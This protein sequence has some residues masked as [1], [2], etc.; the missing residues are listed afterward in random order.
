MQPTIAPNRVQRLPTWALPAGIAAL[1]V[2]VAI[3]DGGSA[4]RYERALVGAE[5]WRLVTAHQ[6]HLGWM[7]LALNLAGLAAVWA[8]LG[9]QLRP[10]TWLAVFLTCALGV[11]GGLRVLDPDLEWYVG[12]SGVLH[13]MFV[14][15]ALAGLRRARLFHGLLLAG[16]VVKVAWEQ[17]AGVD[18]GSAELV[19]GAVVVNAHLYGVLAGFACLPLGFLWRRARPAAA[20][21]V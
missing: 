1:C 13:G 20:S 5:P 9:P 4:L 8:L 15:G 2:L 19:G 16:V 10:G 11:S 6:V 3:V 12:L 18:V 14:A 17:Y 21:R 7:H